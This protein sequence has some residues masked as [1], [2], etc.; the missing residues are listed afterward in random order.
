MHK[1]PNEKR[2]PTDEE[3]VLLVR[4]LAS[5]DALAR[6]EAPVREALRAAGRVHDEIRRRSWE[7]ARRR[8]LR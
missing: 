2:P 3:I 7:A 1:K 8:V 6:A 5:P 4:Q